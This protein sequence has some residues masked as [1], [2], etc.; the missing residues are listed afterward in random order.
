MNQLSESY[1]ARLSNLLPSCVAF[2]KYLLKRLTH[3]RVNVNAGYLAY[4]T[5]LSIVPML[6]VLL[7]ILSKFPV[8]ANVGE[9]LQGYII[10]NFVP[11]SGEAVHTALQEFVANTGKMSAVGGGFLFIAALMLISNIDK[12]LN[13]IWRVKD[14]R[15]L[16]FSFSMYWMVLTLGPILVGA[17]IAATS[18]VTSLQILENE[19]L[20]GAFNLF[21]RW[22]PLLLS[23][24]AF[25][26]LYILVPNKKVHL[27]HGAVGAAVA[28]ILF[29]LSKKGFALYITQFPSYQLI[30]GALA[31][32]PIL[33]VWVYLC[34]MI[35]LLGAEVTAALGEQEHWSEDLDMIHSSAEPQL[36]NEGS[37][38]SDSANSTSQ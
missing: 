34:W 21:L 13:Y 4:I 23:F 25:L 35:V 22:L 30:Y 6:T 29:E 3:D 36:A 14:K 33:F 7:S 19:T 1:K 28:A 5:L 10:E 27:A 16:V 24:F 15:R 18:Y 9:V 37:E 31:A 2:F 12:N 20:S 38:S 26:G 11:A 17:S 32:I 8:F